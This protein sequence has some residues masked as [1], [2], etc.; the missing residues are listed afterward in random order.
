MD[1][2]LAHGRCHGCAERQRRDEVPAGCPE[3]GGKRPQDARRDYRGNRTCRVMPSVRKVES[4]AD[5][6]DKNQKMKGIHGAYIRSRILQY[7][8]LD[9][10]RHVLAFIRGE[11]KR[12]NDLFPLDDLH[13]VFFLVE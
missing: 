6:D 8:R 2:T 1:K 10:I 4:K 7:H 12:L 9:H 13:R 11:L 3:N 5:Y